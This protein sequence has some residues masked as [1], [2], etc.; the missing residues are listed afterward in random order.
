MKKIIFFLIASILI[1]FAV[2]IVFRDA[3]IKTG[4]EKGINRL[5]GQKLNVESIETNLFSTDFKA[6]NLSVY[7]PSGYTE[8]LLLE[9]PEFFANIELLDIIKGLIHFSELTINIKQIN[10]EKDKSGVLNTDHFKAVEKKDKTEVT[11]GNKQQDFLVN[12]LTI[13]IGTIKYKDNTKNPP[14]DKEYNVNMTKT[15]VDV[16]SAEQIVSEIKTEVFNKLISEGIN[17]ALKGAEE[18]IKT[19]D[20]KALKKEGKEKL[21]DI[22]EQLGLTKDKSKTSSEDKETTESKDKSLKDIL[23]SKQ[24]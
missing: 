6:I 18:L 21:N 12:K 20:V 8:T 9:M 14:L 19:G 15:F 13:T 7:N 4:L 23:G 24:N 3:L 17:I 22:K 2:V 11:N 1:V 5:V 16:S 10:V